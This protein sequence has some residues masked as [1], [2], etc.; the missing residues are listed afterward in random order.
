MLAKDIVNTGLIPLK[1]SDSG[2]EAL[3]V[4]EEMK[5]SH[6]PI[7]NNFELLGLVSEEDILLNNILDSPL[8]EHKLSLPNPSAEQNQHIT[9]LLV[10]FSEM[11]LSLLPVVDKANRYLGVVYPLELIHEFSTV[12]SLLNPGGVVILEMNE[13]DYSMTEIAGII[14]SNDARILHSFV[15]GFHDSTR[16]L[17]SLKLNRMNLSSVIQTFNRYNYSIAATYAENTDQ[18]DLQSRYDSLMKYLDI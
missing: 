18:T 2:Q 3:R 8:G 13:S 10:I 15:T 17:V 4:M 1:T 5:V 11:R 14:E 7:V 6:Y 12:S 16:I 9:E